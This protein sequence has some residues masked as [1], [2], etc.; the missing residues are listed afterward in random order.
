MLNSYIIRA[1]VDADE[2]QA[3][4]MYIRDWFDCGINDKSDCYPSADATLMAARAA[5]KG[6]NADGIEC[7]VWAERTAEGQA[8]MKR[9]GSADRG[10][11]S[12]LDWAHYG[13][14]QFKDICR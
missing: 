11:P 13:R 14:Y 5:Y 1:A 4:G 7:R 10:P 9:A 8:A 2:T 3:A 12:P 6:P